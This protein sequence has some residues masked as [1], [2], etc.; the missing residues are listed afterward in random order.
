MKTSLTKSK[1][2]LLV[3]LTFLT[4]SALAR[5]VIEVVKVKG[6]VFAVTHGGKTSSLKPHDRVE[7]LSEIMIEDGGTVLFKDYY[8]GTYQLTGG[9]HVKLLDKSIELKA[10]KAWVKCS[11]TQFPL[12]LTTAN[13]RADFLKSE[14]IVTFEPEKTR[15]QFLVINGEVDLSNPLDRQNRFKVSAGN[16]SVVD[17]AID[18]G[19]PR[20][21]TP[22]GAESLTEVVAEFNGKAPAEKKKVEVAHDDHHAAPAA[23]GA[24]DTHHAAPVVSHN[25]HDSHHAAPAATQASHD[26]HEAKTD[27]HHKP[28]APERSIA[29]TPV[30]E[31]PEHTVEQKGA[32]MIIKSNRLPASIKGEAHSYLEKVIKPKKKIEVKNVEIRYFGVTKLETPREPASIPFGKETAKIDGGFSA[33]VTDQ[34][35]I[36]QKNDEKPSFKSSKELENLVKDLQSF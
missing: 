14:F 19:V 3:L 7:E 9:S 13:G 23:H 1:S 28:A 17:P 5:P 30:A 31:E 32:I 12:S 11:N 8:N 16:F 20:A 33:K 10:G 21:P 18:H 24:H 29:S 26:A 25:T 27:D 34:A 22:T 15:S 4:T 35:Q 6:S 36:P 2:S